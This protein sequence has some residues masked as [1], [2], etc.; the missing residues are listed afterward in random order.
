MSEEYPSKPLG[1]SRSCLPSTGPIGAPSRAKNTVVGRAS[2]Q[3]Y[4]DKVDEYFAKIP[5][6]VR[7]ILPKPN[8]FKIEK[9]IQVGK[10]LVLVLIYEG[11]TY[12]EGKKVLVFKNIDLIDLMTNNKNLIDP[13]F[14]DK[15]GWIAPTARFEPTEEGLEMAILFA[16][17]IL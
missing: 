2:F 6:E 15:K 8:K 14:S 17:N 4:S 12:Y 10:H 16:R 11:C 9:S 1:C 13:H 3:P 5:M 7:K